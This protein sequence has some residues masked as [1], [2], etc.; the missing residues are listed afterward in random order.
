[1]G[2]AELLYKI[3]LVIFVE[4]RNANSARMTYNVACGVFSVF[5]HYLVTVNFKYVSF[6][7]KLAA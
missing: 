7:F 1:M 6:E 5:E 4:R 3:N 2:I